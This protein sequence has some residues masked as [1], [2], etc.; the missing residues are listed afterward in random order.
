MGGRGSS[1][2]NNCASEE[3]TAHM[4]GP[5]GRLIRKQIQ[6]AVASSSARGKGKGKGKAT[7]SVQKRTRR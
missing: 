1:R 4:R 2:A 6:S 3:L 7:S 5:N